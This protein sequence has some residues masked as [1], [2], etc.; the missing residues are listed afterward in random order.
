MNE[1]PA[2]NIVGEENAIKGEA[3]VANVAF[4]S[5]TNTKKVM[6]LPKFQAEACLL[7]ADKV[8]QA[9]LRSGRDRLSDVR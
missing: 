7:R 2:M 9:S 5:F 1:D 8:P 3:N 4:W 6:F